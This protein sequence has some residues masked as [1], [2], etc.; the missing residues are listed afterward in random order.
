MGDDICVGR[1]EI[2]EFFRELKMISAGVEHERA[3]KYIVE[4]K[5]KYHLSQLITHLPNGKPRLVKSEV[6][7]WI[8][9]SDA[10]NKKKMGCH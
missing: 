7:A 3:W 1:K 8:E 10:I 2:V 5:R 9:E 6:R 4:W